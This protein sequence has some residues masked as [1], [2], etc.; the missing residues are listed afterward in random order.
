MTEVVRGVQS[1][2][3]WSCAVEGAAVSPYLDVA[4]KLIRVV[5]G[6]GINDD[7]EQTVTHESDVVN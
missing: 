6:F 5:F 3:K 2:R 4:V 7:E 1:A